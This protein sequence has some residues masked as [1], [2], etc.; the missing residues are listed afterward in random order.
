VGNKCKIR[1]GKKWKTEAVVQLYFGN[2][3]HEVE[4][5]N[6]RPTNSD[7][8]KAGIATYKL[9]NLKYDKSTSAPFNRNKLPSIVRNA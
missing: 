7:P 6:D 1:R 9:Y 5:R 8:G 2:K 3:L 4:A